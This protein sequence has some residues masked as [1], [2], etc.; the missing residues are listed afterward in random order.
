MKYVISTV[1]LYQDYS[2][3]ILV[4]IQQY[5]TTKDELFRPRFVTSWGLVIRHDAARLGCY[6]QRVKSL[7]C[8]EP[9]IP[10][11]LRYLT[12]VVSSLFYA[13]SYIWGDKESTTWIKF[14]C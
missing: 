3:L 14:A 7:G 1:I 11:V 6:D 10:Y 8:L 5:N 9:V 13:V 4:D 12:M 2:M